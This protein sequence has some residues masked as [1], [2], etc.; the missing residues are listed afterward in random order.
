MSVSSD[1]LE[2]GVAHCIGWTSA[3]AGKMNLSYVFDITGTSGY[4]DFTP[5]NYT[6]HS[7]NLTTYVDTAVTV[8]WL[9]VLGTQ[10]LATVD[11]AVS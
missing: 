4:V 1:D 9:R 8:E 6:T 10:A 3:S 11:P 2:C 5:G 7:S